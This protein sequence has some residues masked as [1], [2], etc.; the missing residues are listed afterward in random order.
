MMFRLVMLHST[1]F[2]LY[3]IESIACI[4]HY[5]TDTVLTSQEWEPGQFN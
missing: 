5:L 3:E 1:D 4:I 2:K